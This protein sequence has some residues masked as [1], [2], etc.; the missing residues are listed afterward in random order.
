MAEQSLCGYLNGLVLELSTK[1]KAVAT[2]T[3]NDDFVEDTTAYIDGHAEK[4]SS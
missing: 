4:N 1:I 3:D 2:E